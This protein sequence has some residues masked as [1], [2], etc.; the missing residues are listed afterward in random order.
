MIENDEN[1]LSVRYDDFCHVMDIKISHLLN[2]KGM[3][4]EGQEFFK[5]H[6]LDKLIKE[7]G[8]IKILHR[9]QNKNDDGSCKLEKRPFLCNE[10]CKE[11][12]FEVPKQKKVEDLPPHMTE[13]LPIVDC[14]PR[15]RRKINPELSD[16][17]MTPQPQTANKFV[18]ETNLNDEMHL[19]A[20]LE[21]DAIESI[22]EKNSDSKTPVDSKKLFKKDEVD[23][24]I[25]IPA[26]NEMF[27]A[28][29][30]E[31]I[32]ENIR[33]N[34]EV[35]VVM[36]GT[37][38]SSY[39]KLP[40][41]LRVQVI[42]HSEPIGQR[43]ATNEAAKI[44]RAKY[45]MKVDAHCAFDEG[46]DVKMMEKMQLNWTM[47]PVMRNLWAFDWVC[48]K[49]GDRKYQGPTPTKCEKCDNTIDFERDMKW[50]A[51]TNPQ[52]TSY[53]FDSEPHFQYFGEFKKR[54]EYKE[55]LKNTNITETMSLQGSCF[56]LTRDKYFELNIC[57]ED[58]G[59]WGS[60]GIEVAVKT[61]LSG[62]RVVV[63][64]NTWYG[65]MFRTQGGDFGFPYP[66]SGKQVGH[67]KKTVREIFF[68]N[69]WPL[70]KYSLSWLLE[71]FWPIPGWTE[72]QLIELK[73]KDLKE[74]ITNLI[75][76]EGLEMAEY[77]TNPPVR[78]EFKNPP[79]YKKGIIYYTNNK[80]DPKLMKMVQDNLL[81]VAK[82]I[83][84]LSISIEKPL[85]FGDF[86]PIYF[87]LPSSPLTMFK[88]ILAGIRYM[89]AEIIFLAEHDVMYSEEYFNF[90][91]PE[92]NKY[93]YN[94]N[95]WQVRL[96][97]GH[98]VY[99]DCKKQSQLCGYRDLLL[100]HYEKRVHL[101]EQNG[102]TRAMGFEPGTHNRPERVDDFKAEGWW[103]KYP[104][105]DIRH[106]QN[107]TAS[108]W[109]QS[110]FRSQR[111]CKNWKESHVNQLPGWESLVL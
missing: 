89:P 94:M 54:P 14:T 100:T 21:P 9:C 29:T 98:A 64:H 25:L 62:G 83:P 96:S 85:D 16:I 69:A 4:L 103:S 111:S 76:T 41:D 39:Q 7:D 45:L 97:D 90:V 48:K 18:S 19:E 75:S 38:D 56:M 1:V 72:E 81:R 106:G 55:A 2:P 33:G 34:T 99:W 5:A 70:Q 74:D 108:R 32:L 107:L 86:P 91:P 28:K 47:V 13:G 27:L 42:H 51:K 49:C 63:N 50:I 12:P 95:N 57:D 61:W 68:N 67:A 23:L 79:F 52:S 10:W 104:T 30:V 88:Q 82:D 8:M 58:F 17:D 15:P 43:A 109:N 71:K 36:D 92:D 24:S 73:K 87:F 101:C 6:G 105:L 60:Q 20:E 77:T 53:C 80:I 84:I 65:H 35:I 37:P 93:Y 110:E 66:L 40:L 3:S 31:N 26:R 59:S 22:T 44:S 11:V 78:P 102:F 46:F